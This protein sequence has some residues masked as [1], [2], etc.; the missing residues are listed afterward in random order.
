MYFNRARYY[1]AGLGRFVSRDPIGMK[2]NVNLY[3]YVGNSPVMYV[4]RTGT[5]KK[6]VLSIYAER[7]NWWISQWHAWIEVN[8]KWNRQSYWLWP[9]DVAYPIWSLPNW[10]Y[11][12]QYSTNWVNEGIELFK[13][14]VIYKNYGNLSVDISQTQYDNLMTSINFDITNHITWWGNLSDYWVCSA[15]AS[16]KWN[17]IVSSDL[18]LQ[19][20]FLWLIS[21]PN[22]LADSIESLKWST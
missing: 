17:E 15:W 16:D 5:E 10:G 12:I 13:K 8:N 1:D 2:D 11:I 4:D 14:D 18:N 6:I 21:N 3:T 9:E 7:E 22:T 20:R 19:D